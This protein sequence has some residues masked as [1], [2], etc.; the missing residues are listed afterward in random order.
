[1]HAGWCDINPKLLSRL[2]NAILQPHHVV[3][4]GRAGATFVFNAFSKQMTAGG[5]ALICR[6]VLKR[7][8]WLNEPPG[9]GFMRGTAISFSAVRNAP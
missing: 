9:Q 4:I 7:Q 5:R 1:M 6:A 8:T 3:S 2:A